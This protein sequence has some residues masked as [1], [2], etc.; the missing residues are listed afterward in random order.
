MNVRPG[1]PIAELGARRSDLDIP[2]E[3]VATIERALGPA[4]NL[5]PFDIDKAGG[6]LTGSRLV[7]AVNEEADCGVA[8]DADILGAHPADRRTGIRT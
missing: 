8:I 1:E 4:L 3:G 7:D 2:A 6:R 5:D